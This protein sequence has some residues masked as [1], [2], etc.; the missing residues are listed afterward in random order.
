MC[1]E[2]CSPPAAPFPPRPPQKVAFPCSVGSQVLRH[3]PTSPAR[4]CPPFGLW[5]SRTGLRMFSEAC[6]RSPGSR[7]CCFA[8]CAGSQT[9]QDRAATRDNAAARFA[10]LLRKGVG[11]LIHRLFEAQSPRPL[12]PLST[13]RC[14][15]R[16]GPR[17]TRGQDGVAVSF[18][19]GLLHPLQHAGLSRRSPYCR[20]TR[21]YSPTS[22]FVFCEYFRLAL[23]HRTGHEPCAW[24]LAL[25]TPRSPGC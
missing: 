8:A 14:T 17:K 11:I 21:H 13:L 25:L 5:P 7:A 20:P 15:P 18:L 6:W 2:R 19:V 3:S 4:A 1:V 16:D 9:T 12:L 23:H 10:F 22:A 24:E